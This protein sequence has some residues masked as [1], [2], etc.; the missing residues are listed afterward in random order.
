MER[1]VERRWKRGKR[2]DDVVE[3][4]VDDSDDGQRQLTSV[5]T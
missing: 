5:D 2:G 3:F 1:D 4:I